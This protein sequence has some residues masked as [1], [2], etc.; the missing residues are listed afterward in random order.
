M[1]KK[2]WIGISNPLIRR[3]NQFLRSR[4]SKKNDNEVSPDLARIPNINNLKDLSSDWSYFSVCG[5]KQTFTL[6]CARVKAHD[7][8]MM[9]VRRKTANVKTTV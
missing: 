7:Y 4:I 6:V 1:K 8:I 2:T 5:G 9:G 3:I